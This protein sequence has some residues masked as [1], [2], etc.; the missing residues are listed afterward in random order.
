MCKAF[1]GVT[2]FFTRDVLV[3]KICYNSGTQKSICYNFRFC[4]KIC[5]NFFII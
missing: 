3:K 4:Y 5:Y 2:N 1:H